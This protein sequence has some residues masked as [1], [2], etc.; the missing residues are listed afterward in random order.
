MKGAFLHNQMQFQLEVKAES[1]V[2][3]DVLPCTLSVKNLGGAS[4]SL[5]GACLELCAGDPKKLKESPAAYEVVATGVLE[6]PSTAAPQG[7]AAASCVFTLDK[8]CTVSEKSKT[9]FFR[10]GLT[11]GGMGEL[12]VTVLP[13]PHIQKVA[14]ILESAFQFV[15]KGTK[16]SKGWVD[17]KFKPS[18][19]RRYSFVNELVLGAR[20][21][22]SELVLNFKFNVKKFESSQAN[23]AV[24][25]SKTEVEKRLEE[26]SYLS[27]GYIDHAKVEGV[28]A[29][30][31]EVVASGF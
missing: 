14:E 6:L 22:G 20:F 27:G 9:L 16:S 13:H 10:Y 11:D 18:S 15:V 24:S 19:S 12:P 30:A 21:E 17:I 5:A 26:K 29:D 4:Q 28:I 3:G 1:A 7:T 25:R 23:V 31:L 8:N 2:Q